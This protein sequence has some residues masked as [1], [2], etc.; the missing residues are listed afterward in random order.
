MW[1]FGFF[2]GFCRAMLLR[3]FYR[4]FGRVPLFSTIDVILR[5][6]VK[7]SVMCVISAFA[8]A[9][10]PH[11]AVVKIQYVSKFNYSGIARFS[12]R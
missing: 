12:L 5:T 11:Y 2:K 4:Y 8:L 1:T 7:I 3:D 6:A 10:K 9:E